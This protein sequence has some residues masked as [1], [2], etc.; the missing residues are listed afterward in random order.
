MFNATGGTLKVAAVIP[1]RMG[2]SRFPGKPLTL[3]HGRSMVEHVYRRVALC[4]SLDGV[5][6][7]TPDDE[8]ARVVESFGGTVIMTSPAHQRASDRVAEAA[9]ELDVDIVVMIQ[10]DEP[11][12]T[13]DMVEM[14]Y[15]PLLHDQTIFC[16][17][18]VKRIETQEEF[19]DRNTIKVVMD[20]QG[21]ALYF[22]RE[23][24]PTAHGN[25]F[26]DIA[27]YKQVC[28]IPYTKDRLSEFTQMEPTQLEITESIDMMRILEHG[29][30]V[31]MVECTQR[32]HP[33]DAPHDVEVVERLMAND[34]V[35]SL[36]T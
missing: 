24:I 7:A 36:Y 28:V 10:G 25:D 3:I 9:V 17:N 34:P 14:S 26:S 11:L 35:M 2:S 30:R 8:I 12:V 19:E 27:A 18:L 31:K 29:G 32:T 6:V 22:S 4:Q 1:V 15:Q 13:P 5:F 20:H 23:P 33:V 16:T 21:N